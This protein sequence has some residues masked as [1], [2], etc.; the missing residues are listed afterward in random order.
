M[1]AKAKNAAAGGRRA[2]RPLCENLAAAPRALSPNSS[3]IVDRRLSD[4][5]SC[6]T[7]TG[8]AAWAAPAAAVS[9]ARAEAA[10]AATGLA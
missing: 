5:A 9:V 1:L 7:S 2:E 6:A 10:A 3:A 4:A 8:A